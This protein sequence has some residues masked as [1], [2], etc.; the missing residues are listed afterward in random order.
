MFSFRELLLTFTFN[1]MSVYLI[2]KQTLE[3]YVRFNARSAGSLQE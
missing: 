1:Y 3:N 2:R